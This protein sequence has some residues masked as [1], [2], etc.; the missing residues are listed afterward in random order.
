MTQILNKKSA[1]DYDHARLGLSVQAAARSNHVLAGDAEN[2]AARVV[3]KIDRWLADKP[4]VTSRELRLQTAAAMG[5]FNADAAY[6]YRHANEL[7]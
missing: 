2:L 5:D 6:F 3:A 4:E 1:V 7:F